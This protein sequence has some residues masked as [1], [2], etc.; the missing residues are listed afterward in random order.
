MSSSRA[1]GAWLHRS[2]PSGAADTGDIPSSATSSA[3]WLLVQAEEEP[4]AVFHVAVVGEDAAL[5]AGDIQ[6]RADQHGPQRQSGG[7]LSGLLQVALDH[8]LAVG[9]ARRP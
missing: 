6:R 5:L 8:E 3:S 2:T 7:G 9:V 1:V 4:A